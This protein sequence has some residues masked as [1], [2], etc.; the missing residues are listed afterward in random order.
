VSGYLL[1]NLL[2]VAGPLALSFDRKVHFYTRWPAVLVAIVVVGAAYVAWDAVFAAR[3]HWAFNPAHVGRARLFGLPVEEVLF[4]VTVPYACLFTYEVVRAY[5]PPAAVALPPAVFAALAAAF[6]AAA[7]VF[8]GRPYT[9]LAMVACAAFLGAA[10]LAGRELLGSSHFWLYLAITYAPFV[11]SNGV[12]TAV[13]VVTYSPEA[14][15]GPRVLT[16][17]I[18]DFFYSFSMLGFQALVYRIAEAWL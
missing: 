1:V 13:P 14:I 12:L 11:V 5:A 10:L 7:F 8:R 17:P 4:F 18:E 6:A 2:V 15:L 16:I 9:A 3:G